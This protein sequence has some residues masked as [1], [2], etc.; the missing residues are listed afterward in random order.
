MFCLLEANVTSRPKP[1][2]PPEFFSVFRVFRGPNPSPVSRVSSSQSFGGKAGIRPGR[3]SGQQDKLRPPKALAIDEQINRVFS[4][5]MDPRGEIL[6]GL[7]FAQSNRL[8]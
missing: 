2:L 6:K 5:I 3:A 7:R 1:F 8:T 4:R